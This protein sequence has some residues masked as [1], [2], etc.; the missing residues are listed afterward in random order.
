MATARPPGHA[1][2][3]PTPAER[4]AR[5][6]VGVRFAIEASGEEEARIVLNQA[7]A[8]LQSEL[9]LRSAPEIRPRHRSVRDNIWI[10]ELE[11]D[12]T[13]LPVIEPDDARMAAVSSMER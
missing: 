6:D 8:A 5:W 12:L 4:E 9:R 7:L 10:A 3:D 2:E 1:Q 13:Q 11:P